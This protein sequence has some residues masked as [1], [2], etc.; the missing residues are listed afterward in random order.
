MRRLLLVRAL[1]GV[2]AISSTGGMRSKSSPQNRR[3]VHRARATRRTCRGRS[4]RIWCGIRLGEGPLGLASERLRM[5]SG[6]L[7]RPGARLSRMGARP[8]G[9][10]SARLVLRG[11]ALALITT[12]AG[13]IGGERL[14]TTEWGSRR[15]SCLPT[16]VNEFSTLPHPGLP[17]KREHSRPVLTNDLELHAPVPVMSGNDPT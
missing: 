5:D 17:M 10:R 12:H 2:E 11:G 7:D 14:S 1:A 15:D 8:L 9:S 16:E 13:N 4:S 6:P 3:R